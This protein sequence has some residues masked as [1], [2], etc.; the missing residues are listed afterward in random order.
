MTPSQ[1]IA[2]A[3]LQSGTDSTNYTDAQGIVDFNAVY[4]DV[5]SDIISDVDENHFWNEIKTDVVNGQNEYTVD[6]TQTSPNYRV[7]RI[8]KV[9]V[10]YSDTDSY[11]VPA[12]RISPRDMAYDSDWYEANQPKTAPVYYVADNSVFLFPKPGA[13][14]TAGLKIEV[15]LQPVDLVIGDTEASV[16]IPPRFHK[17]LVQGIRQRIFASRMMLAEEQGAIAIYDKMKRDMV[18]QMKARDQGTVQVTS[19]NL[20]NYC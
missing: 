17:V 12:T 14:V 4:Q 8:N 20:S 15:I 1:I 2:Q 5:I 16:V 6:D 19:G 9:S 3:R 13:D 18:S 7:D 10:K 11:Y